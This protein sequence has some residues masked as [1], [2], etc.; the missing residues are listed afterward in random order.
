MCGFEEEYKK[1]LES[2]SYFY[3]NYILF[4]DKTTGEIIKPK[5]VTDEDMKLYESLEIFLKKRNPYAYHNSEYYLQTIEY[6]KNIQVQNL[7]KRRRYKPVDK[8]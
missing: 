6:A 5:P 8:R 1:C 3:N 4:K 2:P 7:R